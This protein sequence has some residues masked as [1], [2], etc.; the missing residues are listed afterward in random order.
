MFRGIYIENASTPG[1]L[2]NLDEASLPEGSLTVHVSHSSLNYKDAL[3]ITGKRPVIRSYPMIA[4]IDLS[5]DVESSS[6]EQVAPGTAVIV[7]GCGLGELHWGGLAEKARFPAEW[8]IPIP[9]AFTHD[10]AMAIGTAGYTAM[11]C[12]LALEDHGVKP[13]D[14]PI[15]VTG[16]AGGVGSVAIMLLAKA[17]FTVTASTGRLAESD[18]LKSLGAS[19]I[20]D[21]QKLSEPS[22]KALASERWAGAID[23]VGSHTLANVLAA[24]QE[25]GVIA[26]CGLAQ[27][28]DLTTTVAPFILRNV[29]LIGIS[30]LH[31]PRQQRLRAWGRL[32]QELDLS[33]LAVVTSYISLNDVIPFSDHILKG[34][35]RGRLVV[36]IA[37]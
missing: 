11:L 23:T 24:T 2:K 28:M 19:E 18:Y 32:E 35:I 14:G 4:G 7:N 29:K 36:N 13:Q 12:V 37:A 10:Q 6:D 22:N 34:K 9:K 8:A 30:A 25:R 3:G 17:G 21:R 33:K 31:Q 20:L 27:G 1:I 16:A 15:L 5:G 26:A